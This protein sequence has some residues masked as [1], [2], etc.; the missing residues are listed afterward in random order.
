MASESK[1]IKAKIFFDLL[2][3]DVKE[4]VL[5]YLS[6]ENV[7]ALSKAEGECDVNSLLS[8]TLE[9]LKLSSLKEKYQYK[10]EEA[11]GKIAAIMRQ[12]IE[13]GEISFEKDSDLYVS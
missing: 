12:L 2:P 10:V 6:A 1:A 11:Q 3:D 5:P 13:S 8:E 4:K 9:K 7:N